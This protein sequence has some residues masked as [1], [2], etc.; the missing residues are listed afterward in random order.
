MLEKY[1]AE[2]QRTGHGELADDLIFFERVLCFDVFRVGDPCESSQLPLLFLKNLI[3]KLGLDCFLQRRL[4]ATSPLS[5]SNCSV[6]RDLLSLDDLSSL[7]FELDPNSAKKKKRKSGASSAP[8]EV[9]ISSDAI[10]GDTVKSETVPDA[11]EISNGQLKRIGRLLCS[12]VTTD[13]K[14]QFD[15][16]FSGS[17]NIGAASLPVKLEICSGSGE[18]ACQQVPYA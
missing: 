7:L 11:L 16:I 3:E 12:Y 6:L 10:F 13:G 1:M 2:K 9:T 4:G 15:S 8:D 14:L 18:W 17:Q 5:S